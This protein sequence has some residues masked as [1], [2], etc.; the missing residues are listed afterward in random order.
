MNGNQQDS[1]KAGAGR[2]ALVIGA[3]ISGIL[4]ARALC[5]HFDEVILVERDQLPQ[6][7]ASRPGVPQDRQVHVLLM[8]GAQ[9][10]ARLFPDLEGELRAAGVPQLD[11]VQDTRAKIRGHWMPRY[12]SAYKSFACSRILLED[13]LRRQLLRQPKVRLL[14]GATVT[15]LMTDPAGGRVSGVTLKWRQPEGGGETRPGSLAADLVVDAS[16]RSS[17]APDWLAAIGYERPAETVVDAHAGYAGRRYRLPMP[18]PGDWRVLAIGA[19]PPDKTRQALIYEEENDVW[20]VMV[21]G[22]KHDYPPTDEA[23]FNAFLGTVDPVLPA[24]V[25]QASPISGVIGYRRTENRMRH[26]EQLSRWPD[27]LVILGDAVCGFNPVYGQGMSV[28]ALE[29]ESLG[30]MVAGAGQSLDGLAWRFQRALPRL[31][32]PAWLLATGADYPWQD[33][34]DDRPGSVATRFSHWYLDRLLNVVALSRPVQNA[35]VEVQHLLRPASSLFRPGLFV[36]VLWYGR[37]AR[38]RAPAVGEP[39]TPD[40]PLPDRSVS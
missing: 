18:R 17:R 31:V 23:G 39:L 36:R 38:R 2:Q 40:F 28:A 26:Y 29:A 15:G 6:S 35:F 8:R 9:I 1:S 30:H 12:P 13:K 4:A 14:S 37:R 19:E 3:S 24:L 33:E 25:A 32:E 5:D 34:A 16:G 27:R 21:A 22:L 20:M 7:P 11:L 10:M